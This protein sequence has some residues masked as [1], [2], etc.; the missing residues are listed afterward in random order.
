M[1]TLAAQTGRARP[2][3][4]S[5]LRWL[6]PISWSVIGVCVLAHLVLGRS[7][8]TAAQTV[9]VWS[10]GLFFLIILL[11]MALAAVVLRH[12]RMSLLLLLGSVLLWATGSMVVNASSQADLTHFPA[13]GEWFFLFSY[14]GLA[15]YLFIDAGRRVDRGPGQWLEA[16][17]VCGG[18]ACL[19]GLVL[20]MP[21][22]DAFG[23]RGLGLLIALLYPL[24]DLCLALLVIAQVLLRART[25][26]RHAAKL[27]LG[28]VLFAYADA[29]IVT[30]F[31]AGTYH[32]SAIDDI[33]WGAAFALVVGSGCR[34][35][36]G[37]MRAIPR[38]AG[39]AV[40]VAAGGAALLVLAIRPSGGVGPYL[41]YPALLTLFAAGGR[42]ILALRQAN[43]AADAVALARTDDL[44]L[45]PNRRALR[46]KLETE[47]ASESD[48]GLILLDL[49]GF[50]E[51]N[52][53]LGH[54]AGDTVLQLAAVQLRDAL[55]PD[56]MV[57]RLGGD[58]FAIAVDSGD[59]IVLMETAQRIREALNRPVLI[60]GIEIVP[61][62]SI[63]V[64]ARAEGESDSSD[65][66]RRAD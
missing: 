21:V 52:D 9:L 61:S 2:R 28:F 49:D 54:A 42:L 48:L 20:L 43:A 39:A 47:I 6:G 13:P 40:M 19:A 35:P 18:A 12:R 34:P 14:I 58:E 33:A 31:S 41:A 62:A 57:A 30:N 11:R 22:A 27:C 36:A 23:H 25:D 46:V 26:V 55:P 24:M 56:V 64:A 29:H 53:T 32:F 15:A 16:I 38:R 10:M 5:L 1:P 8:D 4:E 3:L 63:G 44:T 65:L 7:S 37:P 66:L 45:L 50:K 51:V 59:E 17:V 60:D